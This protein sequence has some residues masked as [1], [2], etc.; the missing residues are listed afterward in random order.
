MLLYYHKDPKG[1]F[2]DDLNPW[3][4][5]RLLPDLFHGE[6]AHDPA[7][8]GDV[9]NDESLFLGIGTLLNVNVPTGPNKFVFGS[10]AGYGPLP[11]IDHTWQFCWVRGPLT[12]RLLGLDESAAVSDGAVLIRTIDLGPRPEPRRVSYMP[13][14]SSARNADWGRICEDAGL[15]YIDPQGS[16][17]DVLNAIQSS[18]VLITEALHGAIV[19]DALRIP[20][21]PVSGGSILSTKWLDWCGSLDITYEP[22]RVPV[23]WQLPERPSA[24]ARIRAAVKSRMARSTLRD[25]ASKNRPNLSADST[26]DRVTEQ[27]QDR[28]WHF[29]KTFSR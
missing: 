18:R 8:R 1:N 13:H 10:G 16:V 6:I 14:C 12:A 22:V 19:A 15:S 11:V 4:W 28:L 25:L 27:L 7:H 29:R 21:V 17:S 26:L 20:W 9:A 2:G 3:L 24:A 23:L 5:N